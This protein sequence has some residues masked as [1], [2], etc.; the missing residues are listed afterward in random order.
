[1]TSQPNLLPMSIVHRRC[2]TFRLKRWAAVWLVVLFATVFVSLSQLQ[3]L[4]ELECTAAKLAA[5]SG[6]LRAIAAE[7]QQMAQEVEVIKERESWLTDSDS[8]QTL[9]LLGIISSAAQKNKGRISVQTLSVMSFDRPVVTPESGTR[10]NTRSRGSNEEEV[11]E[12]KM[13]LDLNGIA[14]NDL[15]VA[16]F[17]AFLRESGVFESVELKSS[18]GQIFNHHETRGYEVTCVY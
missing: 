14:V 8:S 12:Q 16:S 3:T 11:L 17:V 13:Q 6:P 4:S 9:Q 10:T 5:K 7:Q 1:M 15:A 2:L 18:I